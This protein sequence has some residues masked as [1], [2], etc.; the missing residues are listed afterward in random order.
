LTL[1]G[2]AFINNSY[3]VVTGGLDKKVLIVDIGSSK[4][5]T[6]IQLDYI[7][8]ATPLTF[9]NENSVFMLIPETGSSTLNRY[10]KAKL[11]GNKFTLYKIGSID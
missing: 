7:G 6:E 10:D 5:S 4:V 3:G 9:Q 2:T 8:S 11:I 1:A